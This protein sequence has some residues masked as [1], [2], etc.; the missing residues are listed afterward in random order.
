MTMGIP[1]VIGKNILFP[2][3]NLLLMKKTSRKFKE[4]QKNQY[5]KSS[6]IE[7]IQLMKL[8]KLV[9]HAYN[10]SPY[11]RRIMDKNKIRP[12]SIKKISDI[13]RI[14]ILT[15]IDIINNQKGLMSSEYANKKLS[16]NPTGGSTGQPVD[17]YS[18]PE[19]LESIKAS[20]LRYELWAGLDINE[21]HALLWGSPNEIKF[22][23]TFKGKVKN[24]IMNRIFLDCF[25][26]SEDIMYRYVKEINWFKPKVITSFV[27][28]IYTLALFIESEK[29]K[30]HSPKA[31]F[32]TGEILYPKQRK[33]IEEVFRT[34]VFNCYGCREVGDVAQECEF[35]NMHI[36]ADNLLVEFVKGNDWVKDGDVGEIVITDLNGYAMPLIRYK[37]GDVGTPYSKKC[38]C[39]RTLPLMKMNMARVFDMFTAPDGR[40]VHGGVFNEIFWGLKGA[41]QYQ[42]IQETKN[43]IHVKIVKA[44]NI[45]KS[46]LEK[47]RKMVKNKM[48]ENVEVE[49]EFVKNIPVEKSGKY[50][51]TKSHVPISFK[52]P[53]AGTKAHGTK[54]N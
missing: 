2:L 51:W 32:T 36:N 9:L 26:M 19:K 11:Y 48:G 23:K 52:S 38:A 22:N 12:G 8:K 18:A 20:R 53:K 42:I 46:G 30:V 7:A 1:K 17:L 5:K 43:L 29:L 6:E 15:K 39:G 40:L 13:K 54:T 25:G 37:I 35:G 14:P 24:F 45:N 47:V 28:A 27:N 33:K 44:G 34:K 3:Y 41:Q 4:M 31:I 10:T 16:H 49:F 21:K 50:M